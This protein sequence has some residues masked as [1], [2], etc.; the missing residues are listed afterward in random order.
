MKLDNRERKLAACWKV[1]A[2]EID[3]DEAFA[4]CSN[5]RPTEREGCD[6]FWMLNLLFSS[7][8]RRNKYANS[9]KKLQEII[10]VFSEYHFVVPT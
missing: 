4:S 7:S 6:Y 1:F 8:I 2:R 9:I 10:L 3:N 5:L